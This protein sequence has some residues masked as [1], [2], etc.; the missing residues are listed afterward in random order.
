[1]AE[2]ALMRD[3]IIYLAAAVVSVPIAKRLGLGSILGYLVA[4][5]IIGP[6]GLHWVGATERVMHLS[7]FGVVLM[8][9]LIGLELNLEKLW[10]LRI[11]VFLGGG[12][13]LGLTGAL[14]AGGLALLGVPW[15]PALVAGFGLALSSTA[16][17]M[18]VMDERNLLRTQVGSTSFA[19]LL[20]QDLAAIPLLA[21]VPLL[22][23][24]PVEHGTHPMWVQSMLA[25]G[26]IVLIIMVGRYLTRPVLRLVAQAHVREVFTAFALLLVFGIA[27]LMQAVGLSMAL[28][29]FLAGVL[30]A[31]S[32]YRHALQADIEPFKGLL[33]GL[34]FIGVGMS[35]DFTLVSSR[36]GM[37]ALLVFG[38]VAIKSG[39]LIGIARWVGVP[40]RE[41]LTFAALLG[42]G[43]EFAFVVLSAAQD[44]RVLG[45]DWTALLSA[46]V[47]ISMA[48]T[49]LLF[50]VINR[51]SSK[52]ARA[53]QKPDTIDDD[54]AAVIIAGYGR[55]GQVVGR[56]LLS[57]GVHVTVLDHDLEQ[58]EL[59]RRFGLEV[60]YGDATQ[61]DLL[62]AAGARKAKLLV[63]A[64]DGVDESMVLAKR[65]RAAFPSLK[66]VARARNVRH[67]L[68]LREMGVECVQ[69]ETFESALRSAREAA[70]LLGIDPYAARQIA[71]KFRHHNLAML[72]DM[73][74]EFRDEQKAVARA[75]SA[76]SELEK[77]LRDDKTN[78]D[79]Q[80]GKGWR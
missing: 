39:V 11:Q 54:S 59:L 30:L 47:A 53:A 19:I 5:C 65:A 4:G 29:A 25:V 14:L 62:E 40:G 64:I 42:Q 23:T 72:H 8:L 80:F 16:I 49:P 32:E 24:Q 70:V 28:G 51:F 78:R 37:L 7:E 45:G 34:F 6:W 43:G 48:S 35:I 13:Q 20:F 3:V 26:T 60:F 38:I 77:M 46:A 71:D 10:Q 79:Q 17:G 22:A 61:L 55:Y 57:S 18:Q 63:I 27:Q 73:L 58:I 31:T 67:W 74:P 76:R 44:A 2:P 1:M 56:M 50:V 68:E 21:I 12:L 69:R 75:K 36:P 33:L 41:R 66:I 15:T 52:Q 9:F